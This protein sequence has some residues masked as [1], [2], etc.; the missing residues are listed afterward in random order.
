MTDITIIETE[1]SALKIKW[2]WTVAFG[3]L[4]CIA[5]GVALG[6]MTMTTIAS[7]VII[8]FLMVMCGFAEMVH[9]FAMRSWKQFFFWV[10]IGLLYVIA[11]FSA[12]QNPLMAAGIFT[13]I[14]GISLIISGILR[15]LLGFGLPDHAPIIMILL[16]GTLSILLGGIIVAQ[17]P[18]TSLWVIGALIGVDLFFAGMTWIG[19]GFASRH[20]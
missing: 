6:S 2:G 11:G 8:G 20:A 1:I 17:W 14:I 7:M 13:L 18:V 16:S 4:L 5:G 10:A 9:G 15:I 19:L 3:V 12:I